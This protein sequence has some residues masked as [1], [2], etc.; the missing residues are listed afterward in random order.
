M[1][2]SFSRWTLALEFGTIIYAQ[3]M[4]LKAQATFLSQTRTLHFDL[5][6]HAFLVYATSKGSSE[7]SLSVFRNCGIF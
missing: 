1:V 5:H 3:I 6:L 7:S 2:I 4:Y